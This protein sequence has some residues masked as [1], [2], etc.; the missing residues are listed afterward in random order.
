MTFSW[1]LTLL[2][3]GQHE[4]TALHVGG[5]GSWQFFYTFYVCSVLPKCLIIYFL[6]RRN[7]LGESGG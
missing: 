2:R 3:H 1:M 5:M 6:L 7:W 4:P